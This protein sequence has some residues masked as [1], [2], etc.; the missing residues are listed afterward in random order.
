MNRHKVQA[1]CL[2][3]LLKGLCPNAS[4][5]KPYFATVVFYSCL[6]FCR[7]LLKRHV[8]NHDSDSSN[9]R[10]RREIARDARA[11]QACEACSQSHLRCEDEK[12]CS[13]CK[14][15]NIIPC[16]VPENS[17]QEG[18]TVNDDTVHAAQDLLD[19]SS[20]FDHAPSL[21]A[22]EDPAS[23]SSTSRFGAHAPLDRF[24]RSSS[25]PTPNITYTAPDAHG[26]S[27]QEQGAEPATNMPPALNTGPTFST[28]NPP[29][30]D[31]S[32]ASM[33]YF[34][35]SMSPFDETSGQSALPPGYFQTLPPFPTFVSGHEAP[36]GIMDLSFNF[37]VGLTDLDVGL[38]DQYNFQVPFV[39]D[40]P[41]TDTLVEIE[42]QLPE[43]DS[44]PFRAE[45]FKQSIWRWTP[46]PNQN[47]LRA[48]QAHLASFQVSEKDNRGRSHITQRRAIVE[49]LPSAGRDQLMALV[50]GTSNQENAKR[51]ASAFPN[52]EL[53]DGL[54][55]YFLTS[56]SWDAQSL[57]HLP[58]FSPTKI[59][60]EL[61]AVI[62]AAGA[63]STPDSKFH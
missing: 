57:I 5:P 42:Q 43:N 21:S 32:A 19:L 38:L 51:I 25:M 20:R 39:A 3:R 17:A 50:L 31:N 16:R 45:A 6:T 34:G 9:K 2:P 44:S 53:I 61:L 18:N 8:T 60:P 27:S 46:Q 29:Y 62:V 11:V 47:Y 22:S 4:L 54:I 28:G 26:M 33:Q 14:K 58:T 48:E 15:K 49:K 24:D 56:P 13:R 52:I 37:D 1:L 59:G 30:A 41:S 35:N 10:Q 12:P 40:T 36:R 63:S 7:D 55:Q 23:L